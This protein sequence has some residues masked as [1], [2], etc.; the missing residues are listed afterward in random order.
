MEKEFLRQ[1]AL[2][3]AQE[4]FSMMLGMDACTR[5]AAPEEES[6]D[7][8]ERVVALIG[9]AGEYLGTG[10]VGCT[11]AFAC[12]AASAMMMTEYATV[13]GEV[14]DAMGEIANMIF[15]NV[16][17][18]M[19]NQVGALGLSVPT[20]VFGRNFSTRSKAS[21]GWINVPM[22]VEDD[23]ID[24]RFCLA[25]NSAMARQVKHGFKK[26]YSLAEL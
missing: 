21:Q 19:E 24:I 25:P 8:T 5:S 7:G 6:T 16:K 22:K 12:K 3:A 17:T 10:M 4:V 26:E 13:D 11:P 15:G 2:A 23:E 9:L 14:L 20:V 18:V 1:T